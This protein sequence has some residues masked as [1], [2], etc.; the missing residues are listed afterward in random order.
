MNV[1][2]RRCL[3]INANMGDTFV[4]PVFVLFHYCSEFCVLA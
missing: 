3:I 2:A 4:A 1:Q